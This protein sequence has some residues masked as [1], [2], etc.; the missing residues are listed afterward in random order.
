MEDERM[1]P[2]I[3][4][5]YTRFSRAESASPHSRQNRV[6]SRLGMRIL[7]QAAWIPRQELATMPAVQT[8]PTAS[9]NFPS[10]FRDMTRPRE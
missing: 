6:P 10:S 2:E 4:E 5:M 8:A 3:V 1:E 9:R 7:F